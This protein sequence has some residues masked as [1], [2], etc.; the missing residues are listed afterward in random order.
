M[1][2]YTQKEIN[3]ANKTIALADY[4]DTPAE[5]K[6]WGRYRKNAHAKTLTAIMLL[7]Y[8]NKYVTFAG[9]AMLLSQYTDQTLIPYE[10]GKAPGY[11]AVID[12]MDTLKT[13]A[14]LKA[15]GYIIDFI[16]REYEY[17]GREEG[18]EEGE[19]EED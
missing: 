18:E 4:R 16:V 5:A 12:W 11:I 6:H 19:E 10:Y 17:D 3:A 1:A 13:V 14:A 9:D 15:H 7:G 8:K 2:I